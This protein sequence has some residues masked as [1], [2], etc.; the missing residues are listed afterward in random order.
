MNKWMNENIVWTKELKQEKSDWNQT[1]IIISNYDKTNYL[2][3]WKKNEI[4][5]IF[6][7]FGAISTKKCN[8]NENNFEW[9]TIKIVK[10]MNFWQNESNEI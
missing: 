3:K 6:E 9:N 5:K 10:W 7:F 1:K 4:F 8:K 2:K